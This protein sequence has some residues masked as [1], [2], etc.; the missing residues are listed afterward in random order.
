MSNFRRIAKVKY[1][2][3]TYQYYRNVKTRKLAFLKYDEDND[4]YHYPSF[5]EIV[6]LA[7]CFRDDGYFSYYR[8]KKIEDIGYIALYQNLL[9]ALLL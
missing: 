5:N 3:Q 9:L 2:N 1:N 6:E 7:Y 4:L 8:K